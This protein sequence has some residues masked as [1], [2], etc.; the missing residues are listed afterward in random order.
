MVQIPRNRPALVGIS[1]GEDQTQAI[2]S[3]GFAEAAFQDRLL[4]QGL[5]AVEGVVKDATK[6]LAIKDQQVFEKE[7]TLR[8]QRDGVAVEKAL[9]DF[10]SFIEERRRQAREEA[11][12][13]GA[14]RDEMRDRANQ[15]LDGLDV[16]QEAKVRFTTRM[17]R[18]MEPSFSRVID[19]SQA[20]EER[21]RKADFEG[22]IDKKTR[23]ASLDNLPSTIRDI[24]DATIAAGR[25]GDFEA[26]RDSAVQTAVERGFLEDPFGTAQA[27][28]GDQIPILKRV[29]PRR[30]RSITALAKQNVGSHIRET[31]DQ[32]MVIVEDPSI[33][34]GE[35]IATV[36]NLFGDLEE[37]AGTIRAAGQTG[38]RRQSEAI[39]RN[40]LA[41]LT[42]SGFVEDFSRS[43]NNGEARS[44]G[45]SDESSVTASGVDLP[46]ILN[47][48]ADP[49][50]DPRIKIDEASAYV[51]LWGF[52]RRELSR[53][54]RKM[55]DSGSPDEAAIASGV[56]ARIRSD[57]PLALRTPDV[58]VNSKGTSAHDAFSEEDLDDFRRLELLA[59]DVPSFEA[60]Y[61]KWVASRSELSDSNALKIWDQRNLSE[62]A[63]SILASQLGFGTRE[64]GTRLLFQEMSPNFIDD[65]EFHARREYGRGSLNLT[66]AA[67]FG[68]LK[69]EEFNMATNFLGGEPVQVLGDNPNR[70]Y[71]GFDE[72]G[73]R[74]FQ[75]TMGGLTDDQGNVIDWTKYM[76]VELPDKRTEDGKPMYGFYNFEEGAMLLLKD[77][78]GVPRRIEWQP[79]QKDDPV[80]DRLRLATDASTVEELHDVLSKRLEAEIG[81]RSAIQQDP[82]SPQSMQRAE[83]RVFFLQLKADLDQ[84]LRDFQEG[85]LSR[86]EF[87]RTQRAIIQSMPPEGTP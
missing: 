84:A 68:K 86:S 87:Y 58:V 49:Q 70:H 48:L 13:P 3:E 50:A 65:F 36:S 46:G 32:A 67:A 26:F 76:P 23:G 18:R 35:K 44:L 77:Q 38:I 72:W 81:A 75:E 21:R 53:T 59:N 61:A 71:A 17:V 12:D 78:N 41:E 52:T 79:K 31:T 42:S 15:I 8:D 20:N 63:F 14:F 28:L 64:E 37:N 60:A 80:F 83:Q 1:E 69:A 62:M 82:T 24:E 33:S 30:Q 43:V 25:E 66:Q 27:V 54:L 47:L 40:A 29:D 22:E 45:G 6:A 55:R 7:K 39:L 34:R 11:L 56:V 2:L 51:L 73:A 19:T 10:D 16:S 85:K 9:S 5:E 74:V 4:Q 57:N